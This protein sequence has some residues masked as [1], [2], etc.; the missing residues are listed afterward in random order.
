MPAEHFET[1]VEKQSPLGWWQFGKKPHRFT[2]GRF[3]ESE[4]L[5]DGDS[6]Q[7][8]WGHSLR[9]KARGRYS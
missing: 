3:G 7:G 4:F 2:V 9:Y 1:L 8:R 6:L 5:C